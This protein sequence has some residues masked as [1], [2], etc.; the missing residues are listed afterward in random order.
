MGLTIENART[1]LS[2]RFGYDDFRPG[3][4]SVIEAILRGQDALAVMPTGAGKSVCYQIPAV[5]FDGLTI[6]VSPLISLMDDQVRSLKEVGI[7]GSY[8]NSTLKPRVRPEVLRRAAAGWYDLMYVAPERLTDPMFREFAASARI[9]LLAVDEAHC[10][11]QW[12]QD[13]RPA[14]RQ[15]SS[16]VD[17]LPTRPV[18]AALT[19]TATYRV[20]RDVEEYLGLREPLVQVSGFDR[21][22]LRLATHKLT[23]AER[24]R[25]L[26]RFVRRH[27]GESGI[28]YAMTR[29]RVEELCD[30]LLDEGFAAACYHGGMANDLRAEAQARFA[31]D[32]VQVMV[33]TNAFGMG[34]DKSNVRYVVNDG[35][36]LSLEEYY[37]EAGRAG[38]DGEPAECH[39]L[40]SQGDIRTAHFLIERTELPQDADP[41]AYQELLDGRNRLLGDIIGYAMS[42]YCLRRRILRHFGQ[43]MADMPDNCAACSVCGWKEDRPDDG[44]DDP[45]SP[46]ARRKAWRGVRERREAVAADEPDG[47]SVAVPFGAGRGAEGPEPAVPELPVAD[48]GESTLADEELFARLRSLRRRLAQ[49]RGVPAYVVFSD[50]TLRSMVRLRPR[51]EEQ[52]L[53]VSGVGAKK[54]ETYGEEFLHEIWA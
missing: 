30:V 37:Q 12:G 16:F 8:F 9:P 49:E 24:K 46:S 1:V 39:L 22:N 21:P 32:D 43:S 48:D 44:Q 29:R 23:P 25:W 54:L 40:W 26:V 13:F 6:V 38:R 47:A 17:A 34:I 14:Y 42:T 51:N 31:D 33:A 36:P 50:A 41:A 11:S 27:R 35:L 7:R 5:L 19:A 2:E 15:I 3:Q 52:M 18:V 28:V 45:D 4:D 10:I 20:R 53:R